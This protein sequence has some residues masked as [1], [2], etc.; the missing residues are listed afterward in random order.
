MSPS[1]QEVLAQL[2]AT[3]A[4]LTPTQIKVLTEMA[5]SLKKKIHAERSEDS[6]IVTPQFL[7]SFADRLLIHHAMGAEKFNKKPFEFAFVR[8]MKASGQDAALAISSTDPGA[9]VIVGE[10]RYSLKT[11]ASRKISKTNI[12][13]S[14]FAEAGWL[15]NEG[16]TQ[17]DLFNG[18]K[19]YVLPRLSDYDKILILRGFDA[20]LRDLPAVRYELIEIP[21]ELLRRIEKTKP[22][23]ITLAKNKKGG[24]SKN[25]GGSLRILGEREKGKNGNYKAPEILFTLN[26]DGSVEKLK[27]SS[28]KVSE[29]I[30]HASWV[31]PIP[32]EAALIPDEDCDSNDS[33]SEDQSE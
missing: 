32:Q 7:D 23:D 24:L 33:N 3:A 9:D 27:I 16:K 8:A 12:L 1:Q 26:F 20:T 10:K 15:R 22:E 13:I 14:K 29:C 5:E 18:I 31:I 6:T 19:S 21:L 11:E 28:L 17:D 2:Q 25:G 30:R 4:K